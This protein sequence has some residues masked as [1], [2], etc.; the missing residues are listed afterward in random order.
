MDSRSDMVVIKKKL[1]CT[2][3]NMVKKQSR[4]QQLK[5]NAGYNPLLKRKLLSPRWESKSCA[6]KLTCVKASVAG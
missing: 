1:Y 2:D 4:L 6:F 3:F 5:E